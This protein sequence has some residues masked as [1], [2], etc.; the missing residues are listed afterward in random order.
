MT[1]LMPCRRAASVFSRM[2][3]TGSTSPDNVISPVMATSDRT[4]DAA[5]RRHHRRRHR[6]AGG[7]AVLRDRAGGDVDVDVL[8]GEEVW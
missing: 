4:G 1:V 5:R 2:P 6:H 3:P 7:R 8:L